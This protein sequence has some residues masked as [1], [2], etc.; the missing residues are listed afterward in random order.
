MTE[1]TIKQ[2]FELAARIVD[3]NKSG[4]E[5]AEEEAQAYDALA[6]ELMR[7]SENSTIHGALVSMV[8]LLEQYQD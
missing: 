3:A 1:Q 2:A 5:D 7:M 8:E 6:Y 4:Y